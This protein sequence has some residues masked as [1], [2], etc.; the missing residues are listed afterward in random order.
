M[1]IFRESRRLFC[2]PSQDTDLTR[3]RILPETSTVNAPGLIRAV[4]IRGIAADRSIDSVEVR[5]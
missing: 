1:A 4:V 5:A 3:F 2:K